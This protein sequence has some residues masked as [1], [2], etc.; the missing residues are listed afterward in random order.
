MFG[1][2]AQFF[3]NPSGMT[4][5]SENNIYIADFGNPTYAIKKYSK[6]GKFSDTF[7]SFGLGD[8]EFSTPGG[9]GVD[10][11]NNIYATD[12]GEKKNVQKFD[13]D[14]NFMMKFGKPGTGNGEFMHPTDVAI[15]SLGNI[16]VV[17]FSNDRIQNFYKDGNFIDEIWQ[18]RKW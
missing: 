5:D 1:N 8:G 4:A 15:D 13:K 6:D 10:K 2:G 9:L 12:V 11:E 7:G 18:I 3:T 16:F 14:G 17:D